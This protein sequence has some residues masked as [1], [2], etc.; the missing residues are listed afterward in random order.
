MRLAK[1]GFFFELRNATTREIVIWCVTTWFDALTLCRKEL[2]EARGFGIGADAV[3]EDRGI[4]DTGQR[5]AGRV[6]LCSGLRLGLMEVECLLA[7]LVLCCALRWIAVFGECCHICSLGVASSSY[8]EM[9]VHDIFT[10]HAAIL[11]TYISSGHLL[12]KG[13]SVPSDSP[14]EMME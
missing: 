6:L 10:P 9:L 11:I 7:C 13:K 2:P 5:T 3:W 1:N 14:V 4:E 8:L 12:S